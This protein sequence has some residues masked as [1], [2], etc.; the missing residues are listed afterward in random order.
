[1]SAKSAVFLRSLPNLRKLSDFDFLE[2][3]NAAQHLTNCV[4]LDLGELCATFI[5]GVAC[6]DRTCCDRCLRRVSKISGIGGSL[7]VLEICKNPRSVATFSE[8]GEVSEMNK[9]QQ[10]LADETK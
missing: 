10:K 9:V 4:Y 5:R 1:M 7:E 3:Q 6:H 2:S 8:I